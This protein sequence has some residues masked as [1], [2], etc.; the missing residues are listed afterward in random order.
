MTDR[1][2]DRRTDGWTDGQT[3][4]QTDGRTDDQTDGQT[5]R[6][7][8]RHPFV[9][10]SIIS[11]DWHVQTDREIERRREGQTYK[12]DWTPLGSKGPQWVD[13][14]IVTLEPHTGN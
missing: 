14:F 11:K 12:L 9:R 4:G 7:T 8:D 6:R 5:Y 13:K 2:T 3:D 1:W 10:L